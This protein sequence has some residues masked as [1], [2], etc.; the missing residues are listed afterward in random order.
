M[1]DRDN[2][3][4]RRGSGFLLGACISLLALLLCCS[5]I[6]VAYQNESARTV[7]R[8][9][10]VYLQEITEQ[11]DGHFKAST[12]SH[13]AQIQGENVFAQVA[14]V[15]DAGTAYL[16]DKTIPAIST[17]T[18]MDKLLSGEEPL[19]AFNQTIWDADILLLGLPIEK[20]PFGDENLA[21][22][23]IGVDAS[24]IKW[25]LALGKEET[26]SSS[27]IIAR[28]GSFVI[29]D[30]YSEV[31]QYGP[32]FLSTL[33]SYA[34]CDR[35]YCLE[36]L[37]GRIARG[38]SAMISLR[39]GER[40]EYYYFSPLADTDWYICTS[41][42]YETV[43]SQVSSFSQFMLAM[44]GIVMIL[45]L[46]IILTFFLL[47]R[48]N[49]RRSTRLLRAE[50]ERAEAASRA[51]GHFLS[52]MSHEIRTPLNG[53]IGMVELGW[54]DT[55]DPGRMKNC[56]EKI[57]F[58]A[59]H[60]LALVNDVL[61]MSKIENGKI[62]IHEERFDFGTLLKSLMVV[63]YS[64][65]QTKG[66]ALNIILSGKLEEILIGD[67]LRLNQ[68]LTNLLSNALKFTPQGGSVTLEVRE[69]KREGGKL[70]I[71]FSVQDNGCGIAEENLERIF[72]P[73]EQE[74]AGVTR[75]YGG[76]G[77]GLPITRNFVK[78]MG[79][80]ISV[81]SRIN[82]GSRFQVELPFDYM[83]PA[84]SAPGLGNGRRVL[85]INQNRNIQAHLSY[86]LEEE[87]FAV[88][89]TDAAQQAVEMAANAYQTGSPY[90]FCV[91]KW[92]FP[93]DPCAL[94]Q[95]LRE[96]SAGMEPKIVISG[97]DRDELDETMRK[98]GADGVLMRPAFH[99]DVKLM[100]EQLEFGTVEESPPEPPPA[101]QG[102]HILIAEDNEINMEVAAGLLE[103]A[104]AQIQGACNGREAIERF[105]SSPEGY[106]DLILMDMQMPEMDGCSAARAIRELKR[107]DAKSVL[108]FAM[109]ANALE[110]DMEKCLESGMD[111]HIGKP[112][113]LEDIVRQY[114]QAQNGKE[115]H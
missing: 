101:L 62:E 86:L 85:I 16:A 53:I 100:L 72:R 24:A 95:R 61:D 80:G 113:V 55:D 26:D 66:I 93:S 33:S 2:G 76:T 114:I 8:I 29:A 1:R 75:K 37:K 63:F 98:T 14:V 43:N 20:K 38:E 58:S 40:H 39:L 107:D 42:S 67:S 83:E 115:K 27:S 78:L 108:I 3:N 52:Q 110:E 84:E 11:I 50:K 111:A 54:K 6:L 97:Y 69:L 51:K 36:E 82:V 56:L 32:N 57:R 4:R 79:G 21:A 46:L 17:I 65:A 64:Q 19:I 91:I 92:D 103:S 7:A 13:S 30:A 34:E 96:A 105:A 31:A 71:G 22:V 35:G 73:F 15:S 23:V 112:F 102:K 45:V 12:E 49:E 48:K 88:E 104:G 70:W 68:V 41:M 9:S 77:L 81:E 89:S 5:L 10:R 28:D 59:Q 44:G 90:T 47:Y 18:G 99:E 109:T 60:L 87:G 106:F 25:K 74:N 94:A